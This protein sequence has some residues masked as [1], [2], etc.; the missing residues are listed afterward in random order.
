MEAKGNAIVCDA[1]QAPSAEADAAACDLQARSQAACTRTG[2]AALSAC[3]VGVQGQA[4][5]CVKPHAKQQAPLV[6]PHTLC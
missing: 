4:R 1:R 2:Q 5:C 3:A 6:P